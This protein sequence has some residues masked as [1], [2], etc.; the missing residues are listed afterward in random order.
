[1]F[2][3]GNTFDNTYRIMS[4]IGSGG[5]GDVYLAY[6]MRLEKYVVIKKI[7]DNFV[8]SVNVRAEVDILK[9]LKHSY[10]PQVYDFLQSGTT[11][12]TVMDY[13][14]GNDLERYINSGCVVDEDTIIK[15]LR[16]L[17]EVLVY[18][19]S[20]T[21][22]IIHSDIKPSNIMITNE[23]N[24]CL[25][26]F[27]IS[28]DGDDS[29][30]ISG[31]SLP[32][33]SPEQYEKAKLFMRR[34]DHRGIV[35]DGRS[36]MYSLAASFYHLMTGIPPA[37]PDRYSSPLSGYDI[38]YSD[39]LTYIVDKAMNYDVYGR[40]ADM[41]DMLKAVNSIYKHTRAY[42]I[43]MVGLIAGAALY[44][45][46]MGAGIW[47]VVHGFSMINGENYKRDVKQLMQ[48]YE[49]CMYDEAIDEGISILNNTEYASDITEHTEEKIELL[50]IIGE[51]YFENE[52]Y[53]Y[54]L[55]YYKEA[56]ELITETDKYSAYY[57]D[58]I[59]TLVKCGRIDEAQKEIDS[60]RS[61]GISDSDIS[62]IDA[63][64]LIYNKKY[65]KAFKQI[66]VLLK[67]NIS[68]QAKVHLL[69]TGS[70]AADKSGDYE[71]E[72][73]YLEDARNISDTVS[74][75]RKLGNAY[76]RI[77]N[78]DA[79]GGSDDKYM[80]EALECYKTIVQKKYHSFN[81]SLNLAIC[82]RAVGKYSDSI[83]V[84]NGL[85]ESNDDYRIYMHLAF[86]YDK[87]GNV[88]K[89]DRNIRKAVS[90]YESA[91]EGDK[92]SKGS[93]NIQNMYEL[94]KKYR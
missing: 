83:K 82:Y 61:K 3:E 69:V 67:G 84:L 79:A 81:D 41:E 56:V 70:E 20:Q 1:M 62:I 75:I 51:C 91:A 57:R 53:E 80:K 63:E 92:E 7:K 17:C 50:H 13:I 88:K 25:I 24:V 27:N 28:L 59:V 37:Y 90:M 86:A 14:E 58:Y 26:D 66:D 10:L 60:S 30:Q 89:A 33:A 6:H 18:L 2:T 48:S 21:P 78:E 55:E 47:C 64:M 65:D 87:D 29:S 45:A 49:S 93:D 16:Q 23:G 34:M 44:V 40:F 19:H 94:Q 76:M 35:L 43:Y 42:R 36:D 9:R 22:P 32:Y 68:E 31:I 5:T 52:Q 12:Y 77:V 8:G 72:I 4:K 71:R 11:V 85:K 74:V 54:S 38:P 46:A 39:G 15:W 73:S